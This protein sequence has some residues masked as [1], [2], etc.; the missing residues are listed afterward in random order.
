MR[1]LIR[2]LARTDDV[3]ELLARAALRRLRSSARAGAL[4]AVSLALALSALTSSRDDP[5]QLLLDH[6][7]LDR[8]PPDANEQHQYYFFGSPRD[9]RGIYTTRTRSAERR[10]SFRWSLTDGRLDIRFDADGRRASTPIV[11][12]LRDGE[13]FDCTLTLRKDPCRNG[14]RQTYLRKKK[15]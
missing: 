13:G 8:I 5:A 11:L 6:V 14:T 15:G 10:E 2:L 3:L 1:R 4:I 12:Q 9:A 7:W